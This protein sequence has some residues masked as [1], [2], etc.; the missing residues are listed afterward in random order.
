MRKSHM[1]QV[2]R[3]AKFVRDHPDEW[4]SIHTEFINALFAKHTAFVAR[5]E[6]TPEGREKLK[7]LYGP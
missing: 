4:K 1:D 3:W 5:L 2:E 7:K 6:K